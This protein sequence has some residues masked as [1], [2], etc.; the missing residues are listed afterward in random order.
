MGIFLKTFKRHSASAC[1][2]K[3]AFQLITPMRW[4]LGVGVEGK[5]VDTGTAGTR[6]F[7]VFTFLTK[8]RAKW[9]GSRGS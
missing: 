5:T 1:I 9:L 6:Q 2:P 3:Q 7:G 8:S 4:N